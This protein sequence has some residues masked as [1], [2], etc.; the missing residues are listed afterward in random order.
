MNCNIFDW[1]QIIPWAMLVGGALLG[2]TL[3]I[4]INYI[5]LKKQEVIKLKSKIAEDKIQIVREYFSFD[6]CLGSTVISNFT[7]NELLFD[8]E[9]TS[10]DK[11]SS[12]L[13]MLDV[14]STKEKYFSFNNT[15]IHHFDKLSGLRSDA[16]NEYIW[17]FKHYLLNLATLL[18]NMPEHH[19]NQVAFALKNDF[20]EMRL[21]LEKILNTYL[22]KQLFKFK[23]DKVKKSKRKKDITEMI[24]KT[25]LLKY[26]GQLQR[27]CEG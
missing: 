4:I 17:Y 12:K 11:T 7:I 1:N 24:N 9:P 8:Y 25:N 15:I 14:L 27:L 16:V 3:T 13:R 18:D 22:D 2:V 20:I 6:V 26:R 21:E 10:Q 19:Y 23:S 5:L